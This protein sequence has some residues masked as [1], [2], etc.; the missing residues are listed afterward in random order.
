MSHAGCPSIRN[1]PAMTHEPKTFIALRTFESMVEE[2]SS[3][4]GRGEG[5][6]QFEARGGPQNESRSEQNE[7]GRLLSSPCRRQQLPNE[8]GESSCGR[9][10]ISEPARIGRSRL[11]ELQN[12]R[13][14]AK[15]QSA[16]DGELGDT[17]DHRPGRA[18]R[19]S[20]TTMVRPPS[21]LKRKLTFF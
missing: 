8:D 20:C 11:S 14:A 2:P 16:G 15:W 5:S 9:F 18:F 13:L 17:V 10:A 12:L 7:T 6:S 3:L 4:R 1:V 19:V 21:R